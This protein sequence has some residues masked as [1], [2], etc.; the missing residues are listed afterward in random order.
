MHNIKKSIFLKIMIVVSVFD[1][2]RCLSDEKRIGHIRLMNGGGVERLSHSVGFS[3]VVHVTQ[4]FDFVIDVDQMSY[5]NIKEC[6][7]LRLVDAPDAKIYDFNPLAQHQNKEGEFIH[8]KLNLKYQDIKR[9][10]LDNALR[11]AQKG[12][13]CLCIV[14]DKDLHVGINGDIY[15]F[16]DI[17]SRNGLYVDQDRFKSPACTLLS[18][19]LNAIDFKSQA[20]RALDEQK[21]IIN[22]H[23]VTKTKEETELTN[24]EI[25][26]SDCLVAHRYSPNIGA[27]GIPKICEEHALRLK[28]SC[29]DSNVDA[30][31][32]G[33]N[34]IMKAEGK[35]L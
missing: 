16:K 19:G 33:F 25:V 6:M 10:E 7:N 20:Q 31:I 26:F 24:K 2:G 5:A 14:E 15:I 18:V 8:S 17:S 3:C 21:Y 29:C 30:M 35:I 12:I 13:L 28:L 34:A 32:A 23:E 4:K 11:S 9:D 27:S 22:T 1:V